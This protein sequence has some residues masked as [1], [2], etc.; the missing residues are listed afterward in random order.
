MAYTALDLGV[1]GLGASERESS[2]VNVRVPRALC[3]DLQGWK[4]KKNRTAQT[5]PS[6]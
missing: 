4:K 1:S 6:R 3:W 2:E 5:A